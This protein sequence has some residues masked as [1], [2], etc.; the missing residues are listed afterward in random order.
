[1]ARKRKEEEASGGA[2]E[3][4]ATFSDLMNLL[5]CF[6]VLLFSMSTVDAEKYEEIVASFAG[7]FSIFEGGGSAIDQGNLISSGISQLDDL[8]DYTSNKGSSNDAENT[9]ESDALKEY[10]KQQEEKTNQMYEEIVQDVENKD[11]DS[12]V[13]LKSNSPYVQLNLS[14]AILFDSGKADIKKNALPILS[15]VGAILKKYDDCQIVIE[16]HTDNV[17]ISNSAYKNNLFLST[18]RAITVHEYLIGVKK[19]NPETLTSS[20]RAEYDPIASNST[21]EGRSK[22]RR[23]EIKIYNPLYK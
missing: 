16:G 22:N 10:E 6:F 7:T 3:W 19:L 17:P 9:G 5:L 23:V 20:G 15:K 12:Y 21:E 8:G 2:P 11:L 13:E 18:A 4:M 1:M 14:G